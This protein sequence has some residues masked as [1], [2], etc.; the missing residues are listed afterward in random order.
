MKKAR[1]L[2][3]LSAIVV[4]ATAFSSFNVT[5]KATYIWSNNQEYA[6]QGDR[7]A[8]QK[9][10]LALSI[11]ETNTYS[12]SDSLCSGLYSKQKALA[13]IK[14]G[15]ARL[16]VQGGIAAVYYPTD[17][18]FHETYKIVY[19]L[20]GCVAPATI[21][22]LEEYNQVVFEHLHSTYGDK[23]KNEVRKDVIGLSTQ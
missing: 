16:L 18:S 4:I 17:K 20:F 10:N 7:G 6:N 23:W 22:C 19:E 21:N 5:H 8:D 11:T 12:N 14:S 1:Y 9:N 2:L 13:D 15:K 3:T